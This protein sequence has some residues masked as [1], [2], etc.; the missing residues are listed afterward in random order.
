[1]NL[2]NTDRVAL[3][4][5]A[6]LVAA[7]FILPSLTVP[8]ASQGAGFLSAAR[9]LSNLAAFVPQTLLLAYIIGIRG[10]EA[11][12][13]L[14]APRPRDFAVALALAPLVAAAA[15]GGTAIAG[16]LGAP[17]LAP[18]RQSPDLPLPLFLPL[19]A[20]SVLSVGYREELLYRVYLIRR[21]E[22]AGVPT[23]T[24][25]AL[26]VVLFAAGH[27]YQGPPGALGALGAGLA[28][29]VAYIRTRGLHALAWAHAIYDAVV[30]L[31]TLQA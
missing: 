14:R 10:E 30:I 9:H 11:G 3:L 13:G 27:L 2:R 29:T 28:L 20:A 19:L 25:V 23:W 18:P 1:M 21:L 26:S 15:F 24:A 8:S 22:T 17:A 7:V 16:L 6:A 5:E 31:S 4:K 12:F